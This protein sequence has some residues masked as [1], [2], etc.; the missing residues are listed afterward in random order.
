MTLYTI[1]VVVVASVAHAAALLGF[2]HT[3]I[4]RLER[5]RKKILSEQHCVEGR[6]LM[7]VR[8][9]RSELDRWMETTEIELKL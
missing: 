9:Q 2:S 7:D 8:G 1:N 3:T 4:S 6:C 5:E